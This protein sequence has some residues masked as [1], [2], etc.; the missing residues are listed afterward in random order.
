MM[1][2]V[3]VWMLLVVVA[4]V[5][6]GGCETG[7]SPRVHD[8]APPSG[9][10]VVTPPAPSSDTAARQP[11][12]RSSP[13][14]SMDRLMR[15]MEGVSP[16]PE[17]SGVAVR[18][19]DDRPQPHA[20]ASGSTG[21]CPPKWFRHGE[22][23]G[24]RYGLGES[25]ESRQSAEQEAR[26]N[27]V[28]GLEL[29]ISG[30]DTFQARETADEGFK[31]SVDSTITERVNLSLTGISITE[32]GTCGRQWYAR[33][34]L[35]QATA[36]TAWREDLRQLGEK[37]KALSR[38][39]STHAQN[40]AAFARLLAQ[41]RLAVVLGTASEIERRL[42]YLTGKSESTPL[43]AGDAQDAKQHYETVLRS[44]QVKL[45]GDDQQ[46]VE[47]PRLPKPFVVQVLA[48]KDPVAGVPVRFTVTQ[49]T[50]D[51]PDTAMTDQAGNASVRGHYP[52]STEDDAS[53]KID[54][55]VRLDRMITQTTNEDLSS[56]KQA[57]EQ[58]QKS[59]TGHFQVRPPVFHLR[60]EALRMVGEAEKWGDAIQ[61][62]RTTGNVLGVMKAMTDLYT[63]Q[64][65]GKP[66]VERLLRLHSDSGK[67]VEAL[68]APEETRHA[69]ASVLGS[70]EVK[71]V[72]GDDQQAVEGPKL[73]EPFVVQVLAGTD[74]VA[75]VPV[76]FEV[77]KGNMTV[78]SSKKTDKHGKVEAEGRYPESLKNEGKAVIEA[79]V[80][81]HEITKEYP[82]AL[83]Q[84]VEGKQNAL[85][86]TFVVKEP[87]FHLRDEALRKAGKAK[88]LEGK[89]REHET[90]RNVPDVLGAMK[91]M[92]ELYEVQ[93]EGE[94]VV[95]RLLRLHSDSG[96][97]VEALRK[98]EETYHELDLLVSSFQ[99]TLVE[100]DQQRAELDRPLNNPLKARLVAKLGENDVPV[101]DVPVRFTFDQDSGTVKPRSVLTDEDGYVRAV[102]RRVEPGD[103]NHVD[104][105]ITASPDVSGQ[106]LPKKFRDRL[107]ENALRFRVTR[108]RG[109]VSA[110][111]FRGPLYKLVCDLV[112]GTNESVGKVTVVRGFVERTSGDRHPLSDRI[113]EA[114]K[115]G[116]TLSKQV[117]VLEPLTPADAVPPRDPDAEVSGQYGADAR[118]LWVH[119]KL[120]RIKTHLKTRWKETETVAE[121]AIPLND[122]PR[123]GQSAFPSSAHDLPVVP[124]PSRFAT[125]DEWVETFWTHRNPR[126]K[127]QTWIKSDKTRYQEGDLATFSFKTDRDCHLWVFAV[128][129][130]GLVNMLLPN[131]DHQDPLRV[132]A[133][134]KITIPDPRGLFTIRPPFGT[135]RVKT[136]CT[137][138]RIDVVASGHIGTLTKETP[139]FE[140]PRDKKGKAE[141]LGGETL[142]PGEWSEAHTTVLTLP[143]GQ[144]VTRGERG[145]QDLGLVSTDE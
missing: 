31:Y 102:V 5:S 116:L 101:A 64:K 43:R 12:A 41:Y 42:P 145:L 28:K 86:T 138:R 92:A 130:K 68:G 78:P 56:L 83:K 112:K 18:H 71:R 125:H 75:G 26:L 7:E 137:T 131:Y 13:R 97:D 29:T 80:P 100:G 44:F 77:Q 63:V 134:K 118:S 6:L 128:D 66:V 22:S 70:L 35:D 24:F 114:L 140:F 103:G 132:D 19:P 10:A 91:A 121:V 81:L 106:W 108:P 72:S 23:S 37:A 107:K 126:A 34:A 136:V 54:V 40:K 124:D 74:P 57:L 46:A 14:A 73:P 79:K 139:L 84:A 144:T 32:G 39:V 1:K 67:D 30:Q 96:K 11:S 99:F 65:E 16:S 115:D 122:V 59:L 88:E 61:D 20:S 87:V 95:E 8:V 76:E 135:D 93:K 69:L 36:A 4:G 117:K 3:R 9:T 143:K 89:I 98:P 120:S 51:V 141:S 111:P 45:S 2:I 27:V 33:A 50:I 90:K 123:T 52:K 113:E 58:K 25:A 38:H 47:G 15:E 110:D 85:T 48:G 105:F 109:C 49:G 21:P 55:E 104:T 119:A 94:K 17:E 62:R 127:F 129:V 60:K 82:D 133:G 53:A 142:D